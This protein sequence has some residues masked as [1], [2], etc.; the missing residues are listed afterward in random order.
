VPR[1]SSRFVLGLKNPY[2]GVVLVPR[3]P[4]PSSQAVM[5]IA[6]S[7]T[8][9]SEQTVMKPTFAE[10]WHRIESH[11]GEDFVTKTGLPFTYTVEH[12]VVRPSRTNRHIP[13]SDF[14]KAL[15]LGPLKNVAVVHDLRGPSYIY[16]ILMDERIR[17]PAD[18]G[19]ARVL[20]Q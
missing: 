10:V 18:A 7:Q 1:G 3:N 16:A 15:T 6:A 4:L 8:I 11:A 20:A 5:A 17:A 19:R 9:T 2:V 13:R 12:G 14:E